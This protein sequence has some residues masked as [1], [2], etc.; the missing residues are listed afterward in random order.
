ML[1]KS[2]LCILCLAFV[3]L[4]FGCEKEPER[5]D[6]GEEGRWEYSE[7]LSL[8]LGGNANGLS[9][10]EYFARANEAA[11]DWPY[12][13]YCW[14]TLNQ[15]LITGE[16][17]Y[18]FEDEA[19]NAF[20]TR[21]KKHELLIREAYN[22]PETGDVTYNKNYKKYMRLVL[23]YGCGEFLGFF[24]MVHHSWYSDYLGGMIGNFDEVSE[25]MTAGIVEL[26]ESPLVESVS[27][28]LVPLIKPEWDMA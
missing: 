3:C 16:M 13:M 28:G 10:E 25:E 24:E 14:V 27:F 9:L 7:K 17:E 1:K 18:T 11:K 2:L 8:H 22:L 6:F 15:E 5:P 21:M 4:G 20:L 19:L 12:G 26:S 23:V